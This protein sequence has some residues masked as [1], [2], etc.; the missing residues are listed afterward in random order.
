MFLTTKEDPRSF[1]YIEGSFFTKARST[2]IFG[3]ILWNNEG[4]GAGQFH[5]GLVEKTRAQEG[6][7]Y[8]RSKEE[9]ESVLSVVP[10]IFLLRVNFVHI[11]YL[12]I[13]PSSLDVAHAICMH[14]Y[15]P[16]RLFVFCDL[17]ISTSSFCYT[18]KVILCRVQLTPQ[19]WGSL[20][21]I[22]KVREGEKKLVHEG[23]K[24]TM[25]GGSKKN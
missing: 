21:Q 8:K 16:L 6:L 18:I 25:R 24:Y 13:V 17:T 7:M 10:P 14:K 11:L 15:C 3:P 23:P 9:R 4:E 12:A 20:G 5:E 22:Y 1:C 19:L 2:T